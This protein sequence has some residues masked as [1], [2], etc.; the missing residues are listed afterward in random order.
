M[1]I[2][3]PFKFTHSQLRPC[4]GTFEH[5]NGVFI[6]Y[7]C[8][9][10]PKT[11]I[12]Q[13]SSDLESRLQAQYDTHDD[14]ESV[15]GERMFNT[16]AGDLKTL[17]L[18]VVAN[19]HKVGKPGVTDDK[20]IVFPTPKNIY[21]VREMVCENEEIRAIASHIYDNDIKPDGSC[22]VVV[23]NCYHAKNTF[24]FSAIPRY[25]SRLRSETPPRV[26]NPAHARVGSGTELILKIIFEQP[27][28][29]VAGGFVSAMVAR[30]Q[31]DD[32]DVF[33]VGVENHAEAVSIINAVRMKIAE[34]IPEDSEIPVKMFRTMLATTF[35]CDGYCDAKVQIIHRLYSSRAEVLYGFDIGSSAVGLLQNGDV[36]MTPSGLLAVK[37]NLNVL[38]LRKRRST[39]EQRLCKYF[40]RGFSIILPR[41]DM[42]VLRGPKD[43]PITTRFWSFGTRKIDKFGIMSMSYIGFKSD[44]EFSSGGF[45]YSENNFSYDDRSG[46]TI[47]N[48]EELSKKTPRERRIVIRDSIGA[49]KRFEM[50][51]E[52]IVGNM[53]TSNKRFFV[54]LEKLVGARLADMLYAN[55]RKMDTHDDVRKYVKENMIDMVKELDKMI[56]DMVPLTFVENKTDSCLGDDC[57]QFSLNTM[58]EREWYGELYQD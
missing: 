57:S 9:L 21:D 17:A 12:G 31:F 19:E 1:S 42:C 45:L 14:D 2:N 10:M 15:G 22:V 36:I 47:R 37:R 26:V 56:V 44:K 43:E 41:A 33:M 50:F 38:D 24:E 29:F 3:G 28:L 53:R 18:S 20:L 32:I 34:Q 46:I 51:L 16:P 58:T 55:M 5:M 35:D 48:L 52:T 27:K 25:V 6:H 40:G 49:N 11:N 39:L 54:A 8:V 13:L 7:T 30:R 23:T 4:H